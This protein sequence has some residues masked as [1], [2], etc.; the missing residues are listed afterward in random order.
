MLT[1]TYIK[2]LKPREKTYKEK[3]GTNNGLSIEVNS[4][5]KGGTKCF[6]GQTRY[7]SKQKTVYIGTFGDDAGQIT[8]PSEAN[9]EWIKIRKWTMN[10]GKDP[11]QFSKET[12]VNLKTEKTIGDAIEEFLRYKK[13]Q[14]KAGVLKEYSY[15]LRNQVLTKI[16]KDTPLITLEW[17]NGSG[18]EQIMALIKKIEDGGKGGNYDLAHRCRSLLS[19]VFARAI[20]IGWMKRYENPAERLRGE[21]VNHQPTHHPTIDWDEVPDLIQAINLNKPNAQVQQ[22]MTFLRTGTLTRLEW[23]WI[24]WEKELMTIP[25]TTRGLKRRKGVNDNIDHLVPLTKQMIQL[26]N[27][28]KEYSGDSKYV[29][30][31]LMRSRYPHLDPSAPNNYLRNLGYKGKMRAHGWRR[32]AL[33]DGKDAIKGTTEVIRRQ[34]GHLPEGKVLKAY[35]KSLLLEER[36]SFLQDWCNVLEEKGLKI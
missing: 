28:A 27:K 36:Q 34:M 4:I 9:E 32:N 8:S 35:D 31:P 1:K 17:G 13:G 30:L 22:V 14:I 11:V 20:F 12:K 33:G 2:S 5:K 18:R 29:F 23:D 26:L 19:Q 10:T 7:R 15:K 16:D 25:A 3:C 21:K 24:D 6:I